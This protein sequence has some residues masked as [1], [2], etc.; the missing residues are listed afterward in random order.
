MPAPAQT[1]TFFSNH[2]HVLLCIAE[3][4]GTRM[5]DIALRI[6]ITERAVQKVIDDLAQA[7]YLQIIREGRRNRYQLVAHQHLR[8]PVEGHVEIDDVIRL[9]LSRRST[10]PN[11]DP[12][13]PSPTHG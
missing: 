11:A 12:K 8:H 4:P 5:R 2:A 9:V 10:L 7:G 3:A 13:E 1:W 6:G